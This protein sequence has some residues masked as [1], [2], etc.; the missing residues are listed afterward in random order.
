MLGDVS[1]RKTKGR[2]FQHPLSLAAPIVTWDWGD[3]SVL[4]ENIRG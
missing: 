2:K 3:V 4:I 1:R